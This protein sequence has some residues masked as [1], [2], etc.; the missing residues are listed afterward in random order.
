MDRL[1]AYPWPGNVRELENVLERCA[2]LS[3]G[4]MIEVPEGLLEAATRPG[5]RGPQRGLKDVE[6]EHIVDILEQTAWTIEGDSG[7]AAPQASGKGAH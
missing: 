6:R 7:A 2:I 1:R 4:P 5:G 3:D